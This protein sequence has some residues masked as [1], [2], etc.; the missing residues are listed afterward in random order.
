M[1]PLP[2]SSIALISSL[3]LHRGL[4]D[5]SDN[6]V[7]KL[8]TVI[9]SEYPG[10]VPEL[11]KPNDWHAFKV[12]TSEQCKRLNISDFYRLLYENDEYATRLVSQFSFASDAHRAIIDQAEMAGYGDVAQQRVSEADPERL[13]GFMTA[14]AAPFIE[15]LVNDIEDDDLDALAREGN[16]YWLNI[17]PGLTTEERKRAELDALLF[18][19]LYLFALHNAISILAYGVSLSS[20]VQQAI[21]GDPSPK[22]DNAI[23]ISSRIDNNLKEHPVYRERFMLASMEG[24]EK[25]LRAY[26]NTTPPLASGVRYRALY[27]LFA[28]L[29]SFGLLSR[30]SNRQ[31]LDLCDQAKL[32]RWGNRIEDE[33]YL[34]KRRREYEDR[35]FSQK[36][37]HS[38]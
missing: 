24:D 11:N 30:L 2:T 27:F 35:K 3:P 5:L 23:C 8:V 29:D 17:H 15:K 31:L 7:L 19:S 6:F 22:R 32:D 36:S 21:S 16:D 38:I 12:K 26:N 14:V 13:R 10:L 18:N 4:Q 20:L 25:F 1:F 34:A 28:L 33:G 37:R 9:A